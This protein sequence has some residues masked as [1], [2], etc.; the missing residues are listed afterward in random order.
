MLKMLVSIIVSMVPRRYRGTWFADH[1]VDVRRGA[2]L[3]GIVEFVVPSAMLWL[4]YSSFI[5]MRMAEAAA[6]V[7][8]RTAG[9]RLSLGI[10]DFS[11]G[12]LGLW[13]YLLQPLNVVFIFMIIEA[14]VR[15]MAAVATNEVM[16][17]MPLAVIAWLHGLGE[18][19]HREFKL[20]PRL[21][22]AVMTGIS[23][24]FDLRIDSCRPKPWTPLITIRYGDDLFVLSKEMTGP[25]P[26]PYVYMLKK[27]P[28]GQI[29]RGLRDYDPEETLLQK[30]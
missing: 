27:I 20:G 6:K 22:D 24:E 26:R 19:R 1:D 3:S 11:I 8:A 13:E 12:F 23:P 17:T 25:P 4:R 2:I 18:D 7:A 14:M 5:H 21:A 9:D 16:P 10:S 30:R 28:A 29:V 15:I